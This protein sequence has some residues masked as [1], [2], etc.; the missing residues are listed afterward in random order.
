MEVNRGQRI[1]R[2]THAL[3]VLVLVCAAVPVGAD[4]APAPLRVVGFSPAITT[5]LFDMGF[6]EQVVG[7]TRYCRLPEGVERPRLGDA[8]SINAEVILKVRPDVIFT[9]VDSQKFRGVTDLDPQVRIVQLEIETLEDIPRAVRRIGQVLGEPEAAERT[10]ADF[11]AKLDAVRRSV[12]ARPPVR[13]MFVMGT[14][15]PT[16]A[17][18]GSFI[19]DLITLAGGVNAGADI[20]GDLR[21]RPTHIDAVAKARPEVIICHVPA[22]QEEAA[23]EYWLGWKDLPAAWTGQVYA[24]NDAHWLRPSTGLADLAPKLA[25]MI[26]SPDTSVPEPRMTLWLARLYRLL[27]AAVVGAALAAAGAALQGQLRNPLAEP[28]ILGI[29]SGAGVGVLLG[30]ALTGRYLL[31]SYLTTPVLAFVGA[32]V[33]CAAVYAVAQR[34]GR[35]DPYS[36]I[37]SGVI[38]NSFNGA[39]ILSIYLYVD[40]YRIPDFAYWAMGRLPDSTDVT[41]LIVCSACIVAGWAILTVKGA[42]FNV[43]GLGD[44]VASSSG[45][46]VHRLRALTFACVGLM[47]AAAVSLAGPIGFVGL[48]VPHICRM[49]VGADHRRLI[50]TSGV[51]GALLLVGAETLCRSAG[52][53]IGVSLVPVGI[54]TA[55][56]GGPFFIYLLRRRFREAPE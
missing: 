55:L 21:W 36:L 39:I 50:L 44:E 1:V 9:Q 47:T 43:L 23:R 40:P 56:C 2:T 32:V 5:I 33:T 35:L 11:R 52:P 15:S 53:W 13:V 41:L 4:G 6:G 18:A 17:G 31:P 34:R 10:V 37:L 7:V 12:S 51:A 38:V 19:A 25:E 22:G 27:A 26:H 54:V 45:V 20:P 16:V 49:V 24:V 42:A 8:Y 14:D 46:A 3:S 30:L 48:I 28:Y 29:S